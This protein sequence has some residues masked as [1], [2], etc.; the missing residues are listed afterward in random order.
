MAL[1]TGAATGIG[2]AIAQLFAREGASVALNYSR[3]REAAE[4]VVSQIGAAGGRA[5]SVA[6]D[7]SKDSEVR[8]M[9]DRVTTRIRPPRLPHQQCRLE[10]HRSPSPTRKA[11]RRN[12]GQDTR[13]Q[14]KGRL[15]LRPRRRSTFAQ[16]TRRLDR[17]HCICLGLHR[18][19]QLDGLCSR[20][21]RRNHHDKIARLAHSP[22]KSA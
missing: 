7:V 19:G 17:Q 20:K 18:S 11:H 14:F 3:S 2:R 5:I 22:Q 16:A 1:V 10:H 13:H 21:G 8:A 15:L 4:E 6:A 12:L 9:I